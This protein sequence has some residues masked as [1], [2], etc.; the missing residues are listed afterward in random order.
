MRTIFGEHDRWGGGSAIFGDLQSGGG[1]A[2]FNLTFCL[3]L[4]L[5]TFSSG[6]N[7]RFVSTSIADPGVTRANS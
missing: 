4:G 7:V 5:K 6:N 3:I 1:L 2:T